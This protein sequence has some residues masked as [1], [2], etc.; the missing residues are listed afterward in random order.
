[1][2]MWAKV[3]MAGNAFK[4]E[5]IEEE[6]LRAEGKAE[7]AALRAELGDDEAVLE[8]YA[9]RHAKDHLRDT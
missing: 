4:R 9:R 3:R 8:E 6:R 1:M 7:I 2:S 5:L